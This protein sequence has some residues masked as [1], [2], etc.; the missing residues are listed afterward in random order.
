MQQRN[1][2]H[3]GMDVHK[4]SKIKKSKGSDSID[5]SFLF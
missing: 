4:D 1:I 3:V 2:I 5:L